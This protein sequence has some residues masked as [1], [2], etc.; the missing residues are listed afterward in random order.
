MS[1]EVKNEEKQEIKFDFKRVLSFYEC[2]EFVETVIKNCFDVDEIGEITYSPLKKM[3][4][5]KQMLVKF[6]SNFEDVD[7]VDVDDYYL[8]IANTNF[9]EK[10]GQQVRELLSVIDERISTKRDEINNSSMNKMAILMTEILELNL[11]N[12]K[13][14]REILDM[15]AKINENFE[16]DEIMRI[17]ETFSKLNEN[18]QSKEVISE[19]VKQVK[20]DNAKNNLKDHKKSSKRTSKKTELKDVS[21]DVQGFEFETVKED[22]D[23]IENE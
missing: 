18:F 1:V 6:F 12:E 23:N 14:Q 5:I 9:Y 13:K 20:T 11:E 7:K 2:Y 8:E 16:K 3:V 22:V 19:V 17:T 4:S 15:T 21:L 10:V